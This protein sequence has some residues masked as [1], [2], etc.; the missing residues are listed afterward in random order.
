MT[1]NKHI[2]HLQASQGAGCR[3]ETLLLLLVY[4]VKHNVPLHHHLRLLSDKHTG[5]THWRRHSMAPQSIEQLAAWSHQKVFSCP[6]NTYRL[7]LA[8]GS[9]VG[10]LSKTITLYTRDNNINHHHGWRDMGYMVSTFS[11]IFLL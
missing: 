5:W 8:V 3:P 6:A 9:S 1:L 11:Q 7:E 2:F 10:R 4:M